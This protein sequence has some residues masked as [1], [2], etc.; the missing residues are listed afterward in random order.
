MRRGDAASQAKACVTLAQTGKFHELAAQFAP[1]LRPLVTDQVLRDAWSQVTDALGLEVLVGEP[2]AEPPT[3]AVTVVAVPVRSS[4][5]S[6]TIAVSVTSEGWVTGMQLSA[7]APGESSPTWQAPAYAHPDQFEEQEVTVG[8]G[9]LAVG[10]TLALP[11]DRAH[12]VPAMV[13]LAGSGPQ[14]RDESLGPNKPLKDLAWGLA[15]CGIATLRFDKVTYAHHQ[16]LAAA[17]GAFTLGDEYVDHAVAGI[18]LLASHP[19]VAA[20]HVLVLGHSL[21]GTAA[22]RVAAAAPRV[23]GLVIMAGGAQPLHWAI[24]RQTR[25]L[26]S[27][28]P[29]SAASSQ[30]MLETV[31]RQAQAVDS[32]ELSLATPASALPFGVPAAYW[33][34]LRAYEPVRVAAA[35][36]KPLL[37]VQG[38]RDYQVTVADDLALWRTGLTGVPGVVTRVYDAD[39]HLFFPGEGPSVPAEYERP[40]HVDPVAI[41]DVADWVAGLWGSPS[42]S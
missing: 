38:G 18:T 3:G 9:A 27:L 1:A 8:S 20:D 41:R 7:R 12:P 14:D 35:L 39:N 21:G 5:G 40:Q 13:L 17:S 4:R 15:S 6:F 29:Q 2:V 32:P 25:Y 37:I 19:G 11:R 23:A 24:V 34:D 28:N 36:G 22:P 16:A 30:V 42:A 31:I 26:A 33:L 10:G